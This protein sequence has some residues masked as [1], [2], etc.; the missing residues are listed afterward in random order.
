MDTYQEHKDVYRA[1]IAAVGAGGLA[2]LD[3][4]LTRDV[5]DHNPMPDQAP[6]IVGFKQ[7]ASAVRSS[8]PDF[9]G[10]VEVVLAE[11]DLV[12]GHVVWRGTQRGS[13]LGVPPSDRQVE[14]SA[15]HIVRFSG[16]R[17]AEWWGTAD[18]LGALQQVGVQVVPPGR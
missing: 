13:F 16:G 15:F 11:G 5:I 2:E 6:G 7:W 17:I 18:L 1:V 12:A 8:F 14:I 9:R 10:T 3:G 4:L